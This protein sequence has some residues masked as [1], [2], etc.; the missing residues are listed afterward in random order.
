MSYKRIQ[1]QL[2]ILFLW[3]IKHRFYC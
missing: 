1:K 3:I 2:I